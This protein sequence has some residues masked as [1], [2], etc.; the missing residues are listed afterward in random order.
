LNQAVP[1]DNCKKA[2]VF[3]KQLI[4]EEPYGNNNPA[5]NE[6]ILGDGT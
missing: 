3:N 2:A 4:K 6:F 1:S 5:A